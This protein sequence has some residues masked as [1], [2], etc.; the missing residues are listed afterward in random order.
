MEGAA[1]ANCIGMKVIVKCQ[2][3]KAAVATC[4]DIIGC[5]WSADSQAYERATDSE[6]WMETTKVSHKVRILAF[7]KYD[8]CIIKNTSIFAHLAASDT[9][10]LV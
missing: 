3:I 10:L 8:N 5:Y 2:V 4:M 1:T 7:E 9:Q 6:A